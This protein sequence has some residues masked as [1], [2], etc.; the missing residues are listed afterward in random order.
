MSLC[1][2]HCVTRDSSDYLTYKTEQNLNFPFILFPSMPNQ[3]FD[4]KEKG[5]ELKQNNWKYLL[6][7]TRTRVT[8]ISRI[9]WMRHLPVNWLFTVKGN[10]FSFMARIRI[11]TVL[12]GHQYNY[13][14][15]VPIGKANHHLFYLFMRTI[16]LSL[17][18]PK[19]GHIRWPSYVKGYSFLDGSLHG[20]ST[21]LVEKIVFTAW[22]TTSNICYRGK[23]TLRRC[24]CHFGC[25]PVA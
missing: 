24:M 4:K 9:S 20:Q 23:G 11:P 10:L 21:Y 7:L 14:E 22:G 15:T 19:L 12:R 2:K 3:F 1:S 13:T 18:L 8:K 5:Q 17:P 25:L 6:D 16:K